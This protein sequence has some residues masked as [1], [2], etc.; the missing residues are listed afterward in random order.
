MEKIYKFILKS[1]VIMAIITFIFAFVLA[2]VLKLVLGIQSMS[3]EQTI[4]PV[5]I[6]I[7]ILYSYKFKEQAS[8]AYR[9]IYALTTTLFY[10]VF[11]IFIICFSSEYSQSKFFNTLINITVIESIG[12]FIGIY[13]ISGRIGKRFLKYDFQKMANIQKNMPIEIQK[14]KRL[15]ALGILFILFLPLLLYILNNKHII[16]LGKNMDIILPGLFL[17]LMVLAGKYLKKTSDI[18]PMLQEEDKD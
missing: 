7:P 15:K 5:A 13:F 12:I 1:P 18:G 16:N 10:L 4:I 2:I 8:K 6:G 3:L 17:I 14:E 9:I 11:S